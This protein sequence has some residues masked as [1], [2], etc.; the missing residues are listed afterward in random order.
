ML[1]PQS[2]EMCILMKRVDER[3]DETVLQCFGLIESSVVPEDWR[4]AGFVPL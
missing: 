3:N 2:R 1:N 4:S